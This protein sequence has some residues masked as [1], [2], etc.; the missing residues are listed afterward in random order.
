MNR[1]CIVY[2]FPWLGMHARARVCVCDRE[3][4]V[5]EYICVLTFLFYSIDSFLT[6]FSDDDSI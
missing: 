5:N 1:D 4:G 2:T 6:V 3:R